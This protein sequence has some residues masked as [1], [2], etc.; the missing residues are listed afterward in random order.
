MSLP[1]NSNPTGLH[2]N[3]EITDSSQA[4]GDAGFVLAQPVVVRDADVVHV[5]KES[6]LSRKH[7]IIQTLR[8]R[9][10]HPLEAEFDVDGKV[11]Q[12]EER[13]IR[14]KEKKSAD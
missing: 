1:T 10:L 2:L 12:Q 9:F 13:Y 11:L 4:V 3:E 8:S 6:V 14:K 5:F 7:K